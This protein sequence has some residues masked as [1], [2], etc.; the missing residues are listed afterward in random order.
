MLPRPGKTAYVP[1]RMESWN[2]WSTI[3][4]ISKEFNN[5]LF[6]FASQNVIVGFAGDQW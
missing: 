2:R 3:R 4:V 6:L 1:E 5:Q